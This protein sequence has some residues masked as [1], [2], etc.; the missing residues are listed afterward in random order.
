[1]KN[2]KKYSPGEQLEIEFEEEVDK[3]TKTIFISFEE[4]MEKKKRQNNQKIIDDILKNGK[5]F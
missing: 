1:M 2:N 4:E 5:S 3:E